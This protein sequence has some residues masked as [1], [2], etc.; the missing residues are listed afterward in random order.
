M[1]MKPGRDIS[2][3]LA[4]LAAVIAAP[5]Q[6]AAPSPA[7]P[8]ASPEPAGADDLFQLGRQWFDAYASPE[9]KAQFEFPTK[10]KW[11]AFG[12]RLQRCEVGHLQ[13]GEQVLLDVADTVLHAPLLVVMGS[14]P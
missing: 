2:M 1:D 3:V 9:I 13:P 10:E 4:V 12:L 6:T 7:A 11:D 14:S 8:A 5:A